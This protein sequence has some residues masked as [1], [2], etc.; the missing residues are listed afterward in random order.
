MTRSRATAKYELGFDK[1][2]NQVHPKQPLLYLIYAEL[3]PS[4]GKHVLYV[5]KCSRGA[6]RPFRRYERNI[7]RK[8]AEL[9][10]LNGKK[11]RPI[12]EDLH[13]A[14]KAGHHIVIELVRNVDRS[15]EN[16]GFAEKQLQR[17]YGVRDAERRLSDVGIPLNC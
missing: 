6:R 10:P 12:H 13:I 9:P 1:R 16:L 17:H 14:Y 2:A 11:Y 4:G 3:A 5:G 15:T 7:A 8:I